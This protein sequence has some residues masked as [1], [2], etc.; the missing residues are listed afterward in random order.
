[1]LSL[2]EFVRRVDVQT[3]TI[4][5][6]INDGSLKPDMIVIMT[7]KKRLLYFKQ[8]SLI[9]AAKRFNWTIIDNSNRKN[10]FMEVINT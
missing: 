9:D 10:I 2:K 4:E 3:D 8:E 5:A 7:E 1:M 6:K